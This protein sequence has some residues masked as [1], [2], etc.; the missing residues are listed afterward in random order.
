[1]SY[2]NRLLAVLAL[3]DHGPVTVGAI[4]RET[5]LTPQGATFLVRRLEAS[6]LIRLSKNTPRRGAVRNAARKEWRRV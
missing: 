1:M 3:L 2:T 6:G 4:V 5:G